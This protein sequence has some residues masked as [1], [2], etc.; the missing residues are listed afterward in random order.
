MILLDRSGLLLLLLLLF[1]VSS[2]CSCIEYTRRKNLYYQLDLYPFYGFV[3]GFFGRDCTKY[4]PIQ[5]ILKRGEKNSPR[6][7]HSNPDDRRYSGWDVSLKDVTLSCF[8]CTSSL[9]LVL[10]FPLLVLVL[11]FVRS[12]STRDDKHL[13][14]FK[15]K[16]YWTKINRVSGRSHGEKNTISMYSVRVEEKRQCI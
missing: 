8:G 11:S 6:P 5:P 14:V 3:P 12:L 13:P 10:R 15:I 16:P 4:Y 9:Y 7:L 2:L 1:W